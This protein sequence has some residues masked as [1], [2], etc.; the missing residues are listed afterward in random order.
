MSDCGEILMYS[1]AQR[2][3]DAKRGEFAMAYHARHKD[4]S[5]ALL[6]SLFFGWWGVDRFY[7]GQVGL[8]LAKMIGTW[9]TF[10]IWWFVDLFLIM[11]ATDRYNRDVVTKLLAMYA[12]ATAT[13]VDLVYRG[14]G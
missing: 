2:L 4:R 10:G 11:R 6:L 8:G 9:A 7:L 1:H 13:T 12:P 5:L 14:P 3:P